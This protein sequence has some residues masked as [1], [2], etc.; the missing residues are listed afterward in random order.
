VRLTSTWINME[1]A[2]GYW[3]AGARALGAL[4]LGWQALHDALY[5]RQEEDARRLR[6]PISNLVDVFVLR[7]ENLT[8]ND[9]AFAVFCPFRSKH[10]RKEKSNVA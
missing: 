2:G 5:L 10:G 4:P 7:F 1:P 6:R 8:R 9:R 3:S